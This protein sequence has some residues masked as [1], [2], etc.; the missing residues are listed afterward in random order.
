MNVD[1]S[2]ITGF[3]NLFRGLDEKILGGIN[4]LVL[5]I[6]IIIVIVYFSLSSSLGTG[7]S[8]PSSIT[9]STPSSTISIIELL[10]WGIFI[11][12]I[13]VNGLQ[14]FFAIDI[15]TG[16]KNLFSP[17][18]EVEIKVTDIRPEQKEEEEETVPEIMIEK[19]VFNIPE[20]IYTYDEAKA[21]CKAYNARLATYEEVED[22]YK[23]GGEWCNYGWSRNQL[24]LFPTQKETYEKLQKKKGH[25]HDCGR[26]G[27]NGGYIA[28]PNVRFGVNCYGYKPE[29]TPI[30]ATNMSKIS[31]IP[32]TKQ[33]KYFEKLVNEF[34]G[35][36]PDIMISPFNNQSWSQI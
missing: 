25:E 36:L 17:E 1:V 27:V 35:K 5:I 23:K 32:L 29:I 2:P 31:P 15:E 34:K 7:I 19:Q 24:A 9:T 22:A 18:P 13:L 10:L 4:P 14:Y 3:P 8:T 12:L 30:E 28:N 21:L 16:L 33:E 6:L 20:N 11:F 26:Q